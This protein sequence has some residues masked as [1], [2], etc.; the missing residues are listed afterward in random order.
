MKETLR[1]LRNKDKYKPVLYKLTHPSYG[2]I[3]IMGSHHKY[4]YEI[5]KQ[6]QVLLE[7][8]TL[9]A[10]ESTDVGVQEETKT[11]MDTQ[12]M[13][14][15]MEETLA[16]IFPLESYQEQRACLDLIE[17]TEL[18][19]PWHDESIQKKLCFDR[20]IVMAK[21]LLQKINWFGVPQNTFVVVGEKHL[22]YGEAKDGK[23]SLLAL[24]KDE[25][26]SC[27]EVLL[28][29][30]HLISSLIQSLPR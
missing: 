23:K 20:N 26:F 27:E 24:L 15:A 3:H 22:T 5:T 21:R 19:E 28:E 14:F 9:F 17:N 25:G 10:C 2:T 12:L 29:S 30:S 11:S 4:P 18:I 13:N 16:K 6:V 8:S 1:Q 7:E